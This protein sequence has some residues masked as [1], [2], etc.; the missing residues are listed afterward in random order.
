M[1]SCVCDHTLLPELFQLVDVTAKDQEIESLQGEVKGLMKT[2]RGHLEKQHE[3]NSSIQSLKKQLSDQMTARDQLSSELKGR[4]DAVEKLQTE[5]AGAKSQLECLNL[6]K[7]ELE[8]K[9]A[10]KVELSETVAKLKA[11]V[12]ESSYDAKR[13][14]EEREK[15][16]NHYEKLLKDKVAE[17]SVE[18]RESV[19]IRSL[20]LFSLLLAFSKLS[21][22]LLEPTEAHFCLPHGRLSDASFPSPSSWDICLLC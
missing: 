17:L 12:V 7:S 10:E 8:L 3:L 15:L 11:E 14:K 9:N 22:S 18:K 5:L 2:N 21:V 1:R 4:G 20:A 6:I 13:E 19:A 16:M